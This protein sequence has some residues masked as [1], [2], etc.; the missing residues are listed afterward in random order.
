MNKDSFD[1]LTKLEHTREAL[2]GLAHCLP[3]AIESESGITP[4]QIQC[5]VDLVND[6]VAE[7]LEELR[8]KS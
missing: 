6:A 5:L 4:L 1:T 3:A 7:C 2:G 8:D